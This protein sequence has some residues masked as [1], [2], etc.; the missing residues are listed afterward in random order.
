MNMEKVIRILMMRDDITREEAV[1]LIKET[2]EEI[3]R[4][5]INDA[6]DILMDNLGLEPDYLFD[7]T[8]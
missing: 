6:D 2:L 1:E 5:D 7:L 4:S 3:Y 8:C